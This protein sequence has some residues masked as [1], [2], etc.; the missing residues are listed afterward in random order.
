[1]KCNIKLKLC[2]LKNIDKM[3]IEICKVSK[4]QLYNT[5]EWKYTGPKGKVLRIYSNNK[6]KNEN[7]IIKQRKKICQKFPTEDTVII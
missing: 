3:S 6:K 7:K 2:L 4:L 5:P 1:M